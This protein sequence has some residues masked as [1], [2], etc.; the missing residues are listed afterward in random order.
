M[1]QA[2]YMGIGHRRPRTVSESL[3]G[4]IKPYRHIYK[5]IGAVNSDWSII[6]GD[7]HP[8]PRPC[9]PNF[10]EEQV[11]QLV[12]SGS[13]SLSHPSC[14]TLVTVQAVLISEGL[15]IPKRISSCFSVASLSP[16]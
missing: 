12:R 8:L 6:R 15:T 3:D 11:P 10:L 16:S 13:I 2:Q 7:T 1:K 4:L 5:N 14:E 9:S